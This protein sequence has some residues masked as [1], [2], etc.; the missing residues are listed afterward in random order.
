[1]KNVFDIT[2]YGAI[3]DGAFDCTAAIQKAIDDAAE[4]QGAVYVPAGTYMCADLKMHKNTTIRGE[5]TWGYKHQGSSILKLNNDKAKCLIDIYGALGCNIRGLCLD[6]NEKCGENIHGVTLIKK[7]HM[8]FGIEDTPTI[9]DCRI[10]NFSGDGVHYENIWCF[11]IRHSELGY[12]GQ[13]GLF[14]S[15]CDGFLIDNWFSDNDRSGMFCDKAAASISM[16]QNRFECNGLAGFE[17]KSGSYLSFTGN[18]FDFN[19]GPGLYITNEG[20]FRVNIAATGNI[21]HAS[22]RKITDSYLSSHVCIEKCANLVL[23]SN[24]FNLELHYD[25]NKQPVAYP[26]YS[27]VYKKLKSSVIKDNAMQNGCGK[28]SFV[29]LGEHEGDVI[30]KDNVG[31]IITDYDKPWP[32]FEGHMKEWYNV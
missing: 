1:M 32:M 6:G 11:S 7:S 16:T 10:A 28:Q 21:F 22:G 31:D 17:G 27:I 20:E 2:E 23:T 14:M 19:D 26:E 12:N 3:G 9:E 18:Y 13:N 30:I 8:E 25:E 5:Y 29:D 24:V 4:V 15:G